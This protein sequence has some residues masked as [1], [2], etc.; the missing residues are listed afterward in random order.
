MPNTQS[1]PQ[2]APH[3]VSLL[4]N[5]KTVL[6]YHSRKVHFGYSSLHQHHNAMQFRDPK[7]TLTSKLCSLPSS[8][9]E[10]TRMM[11]TTTPQQTTDY[12]PMANHSLGFK[13]I[14]VVSSAM[15]DSNRGHATHKILKCHNK[16]L[17]FM[18][19]E[20]RLLV[21]WFSLRF[22]YSVL[23]FAFQFLSS[24]RI[25]KQHRLVRNV[26]HWCLVHVCSKSFRKNPSIALLQKIVC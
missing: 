17:R 26:N 23:D 13:C 16:I 1:F 19:Y 5:F 11:N 25:Y 2:L 7:R 21:L 15:I 18:D 12:S 3:P 10:A 9:G 24:T 20:I 14:T 4:L 22:C 8:P 6:T